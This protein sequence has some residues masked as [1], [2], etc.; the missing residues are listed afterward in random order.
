MRLVFAVILMVV[1]VYNHAGPIFVLVSPG[2]KQAYEEMR[3]WP[4]HYK[5]EN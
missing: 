3:N 1:A 5:C 2:S 4:T